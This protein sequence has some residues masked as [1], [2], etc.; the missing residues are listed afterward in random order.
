MKP[1]RWRSLIVILIMVIAAGLLGYLIEFSLPT[2]AP[3]L[4]KTYTPSTQ[5]APQ[6]IGS[7]D[8]LGYTIDK[9]TTEQLLQTEDGRAKLAPENGAITI[10]Q[11]LINLGRD[12][13]YRETFG[14][15]YF[16]TDVVG[17]ISGPINLLTMGKAIAALGGKHTTNLQIPLDQD[18]TV[19]G[20]LFTAGTLLN[21]GL[22]VPA[23]S[24][25]PLGVQIHKRG[26]KSELG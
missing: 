20:H 9:A 24:L 13:F 26:A 19:G 17:A 23:N 8:V 15:E 3:L 6:E 11:D 1:N 22:D 2:R 18:V 12:A 21:T 5:P 25:I 14:N 10:T 16:F 4:S 7:C